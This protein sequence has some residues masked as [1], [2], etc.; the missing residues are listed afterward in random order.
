MVHQSMH[1]TATN[2]TTDEKMLNVSFNT[3]RFNEYSIKNHFL[4]E[5]LCEMN[6]A[7]QN[8]SESKT[9][10]IIHNERFD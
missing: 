1:L 10:D 5:K 2:D 6:A 8:S 4:F 3:P 7:Y 9:Y